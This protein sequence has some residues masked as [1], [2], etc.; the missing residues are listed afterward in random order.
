M[1]LNH[2]CI[3]SCRFA[4]SCSYAEAGVSGD[5]KL[6]T[7]DVVADVKSERVCAHFSL[8]LIIFYIINFLVFFAKI[9]FA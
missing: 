2:L 7:I 5:S 1:S 8:V 6:S 4:V 9:L 3:F